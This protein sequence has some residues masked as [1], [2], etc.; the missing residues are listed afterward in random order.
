MG[1]SHVVVTV[2]H[3]PIAFKAGPE[4]YPKDPKDSGWIELDRGVT[5]AETWK[6]MNALPKVSRYHGWGTLWS[7]TPLLEQSTRS[8]SVQL[9]CRSAERVDQCH[10]N[11]SYCQPN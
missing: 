10:W 1:F 5:L 8:R 4:L 2:I 3:W 11:C 7:D 6:A 9:F